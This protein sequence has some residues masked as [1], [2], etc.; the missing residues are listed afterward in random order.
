MVNKK[1]VALCLILIFVS[2]LAVWIG[3]PNVQIDSVKIYNEDI[4]LKNYILNITFHYEK[5]NPIPL[6]MNKIYFDIYFIDN[7]D[8][9]FTYIGHGESIEKEE[10]DEER[11]FFT[12]PTQIKNVTLFEAF[13]RNF[14]K[15][16]PITIKVNGS[17]FFDLIIT[18]YEIP[19]EITKEIKKYN[20]EYSSSSRDSSGGP[21][22]VPV[23]TECRR[24]GT[25]L[26]CNYRY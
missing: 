12:V 14:T 10:L 7:G 2:I 21:G 19:F 1:Y 23:E 16:E 5:T 26:V 20:Y 24:I 6:T 15:Y 3:K 8:S 4:N 13:Y 9:K 25:Q 11:V 22:W 18:S 17:M